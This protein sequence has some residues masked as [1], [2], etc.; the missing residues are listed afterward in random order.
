M[1]ERA[2]KDRKT[3]EAIGHI[4]CAAHHDGVKDAAG[5]CPS[6]RA[7]VDATLAR[8]EACPF[9]HE[10]NCQDCNVHCQRGEAQERIREMMRYSAPRMALR[11]PLMTAEYLR[12]KRQA[13]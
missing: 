7:T 9:G 2:G 5:L 8:T 1:S 10:G 3:L 4:Y 11:H 6:C 12:K 13:R